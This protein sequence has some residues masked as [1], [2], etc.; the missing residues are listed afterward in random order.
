MLESVRVSF[1]DSG[2]DKNCNVSLSNNLDQKCDYTTKIMMEEFSGKLTLC[3][4]V[5][6]S[7]DKC[8]VLNFFKKNTETIHYNEESNCAE[9]FDESRRNS[10]SV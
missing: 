10:Q 8:G 4:E 2:E 5:P 9:I 7:I 3:I 6:I 1:L